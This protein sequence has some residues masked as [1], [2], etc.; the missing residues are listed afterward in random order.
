MTD[1]RKEI[2][3]QYQWDT[4]AIYP[5]IAAFNADFDTAR[6]RIASFSRHEKTMTAS[7]KGLYEMFCDLY[8]T[9]RII[10]KLHQY[11]ARNFD[12]DT[13]D[14]QN[15]ALE[16]RVTDLFRSF[17][18]AIFFVNP[19]ILKLGKRKLDAWR[20]EYPPLC[21][22]DRAIEDVLRYRKHTLDPKSEQLLSTVNLCLSTH[23]DI[24]SLFTDADMR[25]GKI[26]G[27]GG[28]MTELT[29][30]NFVPLEMSADRRVRQ[31]A[32][33]RLYHTYGQ[34]RNTVAGLLNGFVREKTTIAKI[35]NFPNSLEASVFSDEVDSS[36]YNNLIDTVN[37][38]L[39]V[40]Y[41][42]Y[43]LKREMLGLSKLHLYD[44]YTPMMTDTDRS[45]TYEQAVDT[46]LDTVSVFG[47]EYRSVLEAGLRQKRWVDV[48]PGRG[49][50]G[51][52]YSSGC[53][54]TEPYILLNFEGRLDDVSTLAHEAGHSMHSYFSRQN[55]PFQTSE[56]TIFVAEVASTVN[57]LLLSR[58]LLR[59]ASSV[60]EKLSILNQQM[61]T[62]KGTLF[63][64]TMFAEFEKTV[65]ALSEQGEMLTADLLCEQYYNLVK[66]YFGPNV[67][68][69][70]EIECEWMRIPHFY[71][72]FYV[73]K[74]ATCISAACSIVRRIETEGEAYV[75]RYL[76]FLKCG[77]S[78]SPLDSL[79][80]AQIDLTDPAVVRDAVSMFASTIAEFRR[81]RS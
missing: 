79:R 73:Y 24:F 14:N 37:A 16:G 71:Y 57:E 68:C 28:V 38:E 25:F 40:L 48:Y 33:R 15:Q 53:Y 61:E 17:G 23:E 35:R 1:N 10:L 41:D 62:F 45:F 36:I 43:D 67:V 8:A 20:R 64:Q 21:E 66:R 70:R 65:H 13:T 27:E 52:A 44:I 9:E 19:A 76:D 2:P 63:R 4:T 81:I 18:Q 50:R 58:K 34:Y 7:A 31:A 6:E 49:K 32:F 46:V 54:D 80:V 55:N 78:R 60:P 74:Y 47:D 59:N 75:Q 26:R 72:N 22:Y 56:Y 42:Y 39:P 29:N 51:G 5:D 30:S 3:S 12:V 69:D 11:A 77:G